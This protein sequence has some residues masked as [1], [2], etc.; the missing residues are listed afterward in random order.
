MI[1]RA[2]FLVLVA[3]DNDGIRNTTSAIRRS[4]GTRSPRGRT[5]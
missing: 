5:G 4:V 2:M 3:D 1:E